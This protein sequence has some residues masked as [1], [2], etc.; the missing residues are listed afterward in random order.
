MENLIREVE[1]VGP[2]IGEDVTIKT[3]LRRMKRIQSTLERFNELSRSLGTGCETN[4]AGS[5]SND[6]LCTLADSSSQLKSLIAVTK[7]D[8]SN[9]SYLSLTDTDEQG[10]QQNNLSFAEERRTG[11]ENIL[12]LEDALSMCYEADSLLGEIIDA[13]DASGARSSAY[14]IMISDHGEDN[15]E[16]RQTGKNNMYDSASRVAMILSGPSIKPGQ[17]K[18]ELA[19]LNDIF[20]TVYTLRSVSR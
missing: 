10:N 3:E 20:P 18:S 1:L 13:L 16:H 19:S 11:D 15:T 8:D 12:G 4:S 7:Y 2:K 14:I 17:L 9:L 6:V 5:G